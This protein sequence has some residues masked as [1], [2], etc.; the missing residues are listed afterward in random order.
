MYL[1]G[2]GEM[3]GTFKITLGQIALVAS[4]TLIAL[5][6]V[7]TAVFV[8]KVGAVHFNED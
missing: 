6:M 8:I 1:A 2:D 5:V 4:F 3:Q 7:G